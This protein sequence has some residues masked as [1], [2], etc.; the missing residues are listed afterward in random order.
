[1]PTAAPSYIPTAI[2]TVVPTAVPSLSP[3]AQPQSPA[4]IS[5]GA[6]VGIVLG[7]L[8][9]AVIMLSFLY[10]YGQVIVTQV[11][12]YCSSERATQLRFEQEMFEL[13][14]PNRV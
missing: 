3:T 10:F 12:I 6:I 9:A 11:S 8:F 2:F 1:M 5:D 7:I 13:T 14:N 4:T